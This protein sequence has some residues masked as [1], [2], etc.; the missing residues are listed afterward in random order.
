MSL[1]ST[2]SVSTQRSCAFTNIKRYGADNGK[3]SRTFLINFSSKAASSH[4]VNGV[5]FPC[6]QKHR[7]VR[8]MNVKKAKTSDDFIATKERVAVIGGGGRESALVAKYLESTHVGSVVAIPGNSFMKIGNPVETFPGLKTTDVEK[9]VEVCRDRKVSLV[10]VPQDNA[11]AA[12]VVDALRREGI[13]VLG[14]EKAAGEIES[15]KA[16]ARRFGVEH[17]LPQPR[18]RIFY[19]QNDGIS[20]IKREPV[21]PRFIKASGLCEGKGAIPANTK[22]EA[23]EAVELMSGFKNK[24]G[25][26]YLIEDWIRNKDGSD[27]EEVSAFGI[28]DGNRIK[29]IGYAQDHKR[30]NNFDQGKNTGGTGCSTPPLVLTESVKSQIEVIFDKTITSLKNENRTYVGILYLGG[31][32]VDQGNGLTPYII[33][34][35]ARWG[36]PEAQAIIPGIKNDLFAVSMQTVG[37]DIKNLDIETDGK[38]RVA[39]AGMSKGYPDDYGDVIGKQIFGLDKVMKMDGIRLY[40]AGITVQEG[41]YYASGGRLFYVVGEGN[42]VLEA[43]EKAYSAMA[44]VFVEGNNLHYRTDIGWRDAQRTLVNG[45]KRS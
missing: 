28:S 38:A 14:P 9:I 37:G 25:R 13:P 27:G 32:L 21:V 19:S 3:T 45:I 42:N 40:G 5:D 2:T 7:L 12:G 39:I 41:K 22:M 23:I 16:F 17:A 34:W 43:R 24:A 11:I 1:L 33:E 26:V 4:Q 36:D 8:Y 29:I 10:D 18:F 30:Q 6:V 31:I 44:V 35:N 20:Y 15:D